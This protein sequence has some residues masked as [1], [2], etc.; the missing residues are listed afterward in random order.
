[1]NSRCGRFRAS[2]LGHPAP[3]NMEHTVGQLN[4][5]SAWVR[6]AQTLVGEGLDEFPDRWAF[7][8]GSLRLWRRSSATFSRTARASRAV[9][10]NSPRAKNKNRE[11]TTA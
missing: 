2:P 4:S 10:K 9:L 8:Y 7:R 6:L 5:S 11:S 3:M 1:M